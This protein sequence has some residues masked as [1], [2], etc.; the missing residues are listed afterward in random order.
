MPAPLRTPDELLAVLHGAFPPVD[1]AYAMR[2]DHLDDHSIR[3][4]API[5]DRAL[6]AR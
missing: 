2:I 6:P 5:G 1:P 3:M 4:R